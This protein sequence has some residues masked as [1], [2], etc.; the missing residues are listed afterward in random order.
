MLI[1]AFTP[2]GHSGWISSS[3]P[4]LTEYPKQT[5]ALLWHMGEKGREQPSLTDRLS[6]CL[7]K[8]YHVIN[9]ACDRGVRDVIGWVMRARGYVGQY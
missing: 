9:E 2:E 4:S 1:F 5:K 3:P 6:L 7:Y 8:R